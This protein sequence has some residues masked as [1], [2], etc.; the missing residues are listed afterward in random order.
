MYDYTYD[1]SGKCSMCKKPSY[2]RSGSQYL[3]QWCLDMW[4]IR[5]GDPG[6]ESILPCDRDPDDEE[7][8]PEMCREEIRQW[9]KKMSEY[10]C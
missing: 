6:M 5:D 1:R 2:A 3:C 4:E 8:Y 9:T 10:K 7:K